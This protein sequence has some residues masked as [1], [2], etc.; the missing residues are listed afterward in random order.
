M[1]RF[2]RKVISV[3]DKKKILERLEMEGLEEVDEIEYTEDIAVYNFF[4]SFDDAE[5][6]AAREFAN[7]NYDDAEGEDSWNEEYFL[8]YLLDVAT[9]NVRDILED[10]EEE[11]EME[12][13]FT[14]YE[15]DKNRH[16]K[17][18]FTIVLGEEGLEF[19]IEDIM[20]ELEL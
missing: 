12:G 20:D 15:L 13:E 10:L 17:A 4:Y 3:L 7:E 19:D 9:D 11:F 8:P 1:L 2:L 5:L 6:D 18:E 14:V 16:D